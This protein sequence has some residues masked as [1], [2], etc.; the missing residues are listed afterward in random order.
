MWSGSPKAVQL[1][2]VLCW[3]P[4]ATAVTTGCG[5][6]II[7]GGAVAVWTKEKCMHAVRASVRFFN[8]NITSN[9]EKIVPRNVNTYVIMM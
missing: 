5:R 7:L 8:Y 6:D 2:V 9:R 3:T 1:N 4:S